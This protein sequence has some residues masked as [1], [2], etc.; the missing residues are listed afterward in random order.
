MR[1][2]SFVWICTI[3]PV[4][5]LNS[6]RAG[7]LLLMMVSQMSRWVG[8]CLAVGHL[9]ALAT[10]GHLPS[11]LFL[12]GILPWCLSLMPH[13]TAL[14]LVTHISGTELKMYL[15]PLNLLLKSWRF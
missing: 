15:V 2:V 9:T 11:P 6:V 10:T 5:R 3:F 7:I 8:G 14:A 1:I 13:F 4:I 12:S